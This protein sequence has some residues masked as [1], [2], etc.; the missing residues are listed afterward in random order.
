MSY[1]I[2]GWIEWEVEGGCDFNIVKGKFRQ[3]LFIYIYIYN[4][5]KNMQKIISLT[6][7]RILA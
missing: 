6:I 3:V 7:I 1:V 4:R 5:F 2:Y